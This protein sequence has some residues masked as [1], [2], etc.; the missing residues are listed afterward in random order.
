MEEQR[1]RGR[2]YKQLF[3]NLKKKVRYWNLKEKALEL[4]LWRNHFG[5][6]H[7]SV[8]RPFVMKVSMKQNW[9]K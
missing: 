7:G 8:V 1:R 5:R 4:I 6:G 2:R 3:D 9:R